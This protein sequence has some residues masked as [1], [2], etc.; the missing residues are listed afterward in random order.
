MSAVIDSGHAHDEARA[1]P[2]Q[3]DHALDHQRPTNKDIGTLYLL[4]QFSPLF[5][6]G[7]TLA[8]RHPRRAVSAGSAVLASGSSSTSS[9]RMH[10]L[11]HGCSARSCRAF[12]RVRQLASAD[13]DRRAPTCLLRALNN[14]SFWLLPVGALLLVGS[15]FAPGGATAAGWTIYAPLSHADGTGDGFRDLRAPHHG[16]VLDHGLDQHHHHH[17]QHARAGDD[18]HT[19]AAF[20]WTWL[21]T[22]YLLIAVMPV[23]AGCHHDA[24]AD[25]HSAPLLQRRGRWRPG[26]VPAHLLVLRPPRGLYI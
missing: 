11:N 7:G 24:A 6:A 2:L 22:A 19:D 9:P 12:R 16:R 5:L 8:A 21:I 26:D 3:G 17:P 1:G 25:R 13:D 20:V 23:L 10:G 4:V 14:W 18:A 15:F